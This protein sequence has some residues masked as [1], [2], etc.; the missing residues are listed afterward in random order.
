MREA[1]CLIVLVRGHE[2]QNERKEAC[3]VLLALCDIH[4]K[5]MIANPDK[6]KGKKNKPVYKSGA[7][8]IAKALIA[9]KQEQT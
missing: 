9:I 8:A 2:D 3:D 1:E 5:G 7:I 6:V 4:D